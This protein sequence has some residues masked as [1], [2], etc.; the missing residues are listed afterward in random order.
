MHTA[1]GREQRRRQ[2]RPQPSTTPVDLRG[3]RAAPGAASG[4]RVSVPL[5][6]RESSGGADPLRSEVDAAGSGRLWGTWEWLGATSAPSSGPRAVLARQPRR[7]AA[8][9]VHRP[10]FLTWAGVLGRRNDSEVNRR[11]VPGRSYFPPHWFPG[12]GVGRAISARGPEGGARCFRKPG[13]GR[14]F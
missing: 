4:A 8:P 7:G 5:T 12:R 13:G 14:D 10:S 6:S 3:G 11:G 2:G 1:P 9:D